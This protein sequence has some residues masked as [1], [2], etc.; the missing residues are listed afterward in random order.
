MYLS[1]R[2][3]RIQIKRKESKHHVAKR[4]HQ[5]IIGNNNN[6]HPVEKGKLSN[7]QSKEALCSMR[8]M[9]LYIHLNCKRETYQKSQG[10]TKQKEE[11]AG[12]MKLTT[13]NARQ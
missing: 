13:N 12:E 6:I 10:K 2:K 9:Y 8:L 3:Y 11:K 5:H 1:R 7:K 4:T